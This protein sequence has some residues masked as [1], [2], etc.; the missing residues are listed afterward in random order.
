MKNSTKVMMA[1]IMVTALIVSMASA[2][3]A[4]K[5]K[6]NVPTKE[7]FLNEHMSISTIRIRMV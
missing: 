2:F 6:S 7:E 4:C 3:A 5:K 1:K